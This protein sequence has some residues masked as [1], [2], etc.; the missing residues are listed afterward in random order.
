VRWLA[1]ALVLAF[2][3]TASA[4]E[5]LELT[6]EAP[7]GCP[8]GEAVVLEV[9]R[10]VGGALP[11]GAPI[12][13]TA[14]ASA[15]ES[16][17]ALEL[18]TEVEG[19]LGERTLS[20][21]RCDE[22]AAAA[23]LI[24]ALMIDPEA[25]LRAEPTP[26]TAFAPAAPVEHEPIA[27]LLSVPTVEAE[28]PAPPPPIS[29]PPPPSEAP[30]GSIGVGA[31]LDVGTL[32]AP[33]AAIF[34]AGGL[35]VTLVDVR[36]RAVLLTP[37]IASTE[38]DGLEITAELWAVT[39]GVVSCLRPIDVF[40]ELGICLAVEAG[41]VFG[42]SAGISAPTFGAG[43]WLGAGGGLD[44]A[45]RALPWLS[46]ELLAEVLGQVVAQEFWVRVDGMERAV[47]VPV[48][49]TGRFGAAVNVHF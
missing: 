2:A 36:V 42:R 37:Q 13:A 27:P 26:P 15:T 17:F 49:A 21:D 28:P 18:R 34:I 38:V 5:R 41:A 22:L 43:F 48:R 3:S 23:S 25:A 35:G 32:P 14:R 16:G 19:A 24:L 47:Y 46:L 31:A 30:A 8:S 4:Q 10:L 29:E 39:G 6:W 11:E 7:E 12:H 45:W 33:T 9:T 40:R 20:A 44:L 1:A